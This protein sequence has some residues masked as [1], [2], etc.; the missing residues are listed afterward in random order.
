[1]IRDP[2]QH[3]INLGMEI[4]AAFIAPSC[5]QTRLIP[6]EP[7]LPMREKIHRNDSG[8]MGP[9]FENRA[10]PVQ[11]RLQGGRAILLTPRPQDQ[12]V[13]TGK[14]IDAVQLDKPQ[15]IDHATQVSPFARTRRAA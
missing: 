9:M 11:Q 8:I 12:V 13:G 10:F 7:K 5:R 4:I 6:F 1:M 15:I 14:S 2:A 3:G